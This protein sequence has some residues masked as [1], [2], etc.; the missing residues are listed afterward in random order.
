MFKCI[1]AVYMA[2]HWHS[3]KGCLLAH[4]VYPRGQKLGISVKSN[5]YC[6]VSCV[7]C[8]LLFCHQILLW[9][10]Y[11]AVVLSDSPA[12][13]N[14]LGYVR[15]WSAERSLRL[16]D[17]DMSVELRRKIC[18]CV[19]V[20]HWQIPANVTALCSAVA[21]TNCVVDNTL[22]T[23]LIYYDCPSLGLGLLSAMYG[24]VGFLFVITDHFSNWC[25]REIQISYLSNS[26]CL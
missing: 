17:R 25:Y 19:I 12:D 26:K 18:W 6:S 15:E 3:W 23:Q 22:Y 14:V 2:L 1:N 16:K 20:N 7:S 4:Q 11:C 9:I 8:V 21:K 10:L 24:R 13:G 5:H